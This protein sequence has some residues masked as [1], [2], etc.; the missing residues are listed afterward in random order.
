LVVAKKD[1][2]KINK[3]IKKQ[4]E[5]RQFIFLMLNKQKLKDE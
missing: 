5:K 1:V 2:S 3:D 4:K